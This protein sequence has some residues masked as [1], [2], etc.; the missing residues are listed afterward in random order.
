MGSLIGIGLRAGTV[1]RKD[2]TDLTLARAMYDNENDEWTRQER[3]TR[4]GDT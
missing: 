2:K 1:Q 3:W 4:L